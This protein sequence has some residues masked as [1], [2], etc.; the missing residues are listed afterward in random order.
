MLKR[1]PS[2]VSEKEKHQKPKLFKS[3]KMNLSPYP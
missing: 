2:N 1:K 3:K